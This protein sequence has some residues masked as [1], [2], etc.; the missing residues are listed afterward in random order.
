MSHAD[1]V[2]VE[3]DAEGKAIRHHFVSTPDV[4]EPNFYRDVRSFEAFRNPF[5]PAR[6]KNSQRRFFVKWLDEHKISET[7][8]K[9]TCKRTGLEYVVVPEVHHESVDAFY[10]YIGYDRKFKK[11]LEQ[12]TP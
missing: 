6:R 11:L 7:V 8:W 1:F 4:S 9:S 12:G 5:Y 3:Q 10:A 2:A